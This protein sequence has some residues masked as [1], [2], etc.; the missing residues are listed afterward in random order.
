MCE[1]AIIA[2][3]LGLAGIAGAAASIARILLVIF[4]VPGLL[5]LFAV[6]VQGRPI[7][8]AGHSGPESRR[9]PA[10][11]DRCCRFRSPAVG[12]ASRS[13]TIRS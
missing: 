2:A 3:A 10:P 4:H 5:S 8:Q 13:R 12:A 7:R 11:L 9:R 1:T 6:G